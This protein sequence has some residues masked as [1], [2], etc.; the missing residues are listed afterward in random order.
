M[1]MIHSVALNV[2]AL[3]KPDM[4]IVCAVGSEGVRTQHSALPT[5]PVLGLVECPQDEGNVEVR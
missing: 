2:L 5:Y 4:K 3:G 1:H